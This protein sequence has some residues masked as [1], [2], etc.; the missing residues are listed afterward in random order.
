[1]KRSVLII[2]DDL[3]VALALEDMLIEMGL[4][5]CDTV[6]SEDDAVEAAIRHHP[7][8][9]VSDFHLKNGNGV[10]AS[11]RIQSVMDVSVLFISGSRKEVEQ[12]VPTAICID[13]PFTLTSVERGLT[14]VLSACQARADPSVSGPHV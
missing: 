13:K 14:A 9:V 3:I 1:M 12:R 10:S 2:E 7:D 4:E 5:I 6:I 11:L 8:I